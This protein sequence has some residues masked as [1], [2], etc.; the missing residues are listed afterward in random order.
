MRLMTLPLTE[1]RYE[2][3]YCKIFA[4]ISQTKK[5]FSSQYIRAGNDTICETEARN[6]IRKLLIGVTPVNINK[7]VREEKDKYSTLTLYLV[8][9]KMEDGKFIPICYN[10]IKRCH[11]PFS[12]LKKHLHI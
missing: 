8:D 7:I 9:G 4:P 12:V 3:H 5:L 11:I 10:T 6:F 2:V 1:K